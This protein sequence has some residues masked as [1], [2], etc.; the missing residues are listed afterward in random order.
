[1]PP[2]VIQPVGGGDVSSF[3]VNFGGATGARWAAA[4]GPASMLD[5]AAREASF[6]EV[7]MVRRWLGLP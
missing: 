2:F 1:M 4:L 3:A 6:A 7:C 5:T